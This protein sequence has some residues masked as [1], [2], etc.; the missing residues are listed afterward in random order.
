MSTNKSSWT[1]GSGPS[2]PPAAREE[3][4]VAVKVDERMLTVTLADGRVISVPLAWYPRLYF[5]TADQR[6]DWRFVAK[7]E[8]M[9]WPQ[10]D[11]DIA[12]ADMLHG[13]PAPRHSHLIRTGHEQRP[14]EQ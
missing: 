12:V 11:E 3:R 8:G 2:A 9:H 1:L 5:A 6:R 7:G 14:A 13:G 4:A 10:I